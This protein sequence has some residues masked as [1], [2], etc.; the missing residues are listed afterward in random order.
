MDLDKL[1]TSVEERAREFILYILSF[2]RR[3]SDS[4]Q[5]ALTEVENKV[6]IFSLA[7]AV[8]G[9]YITRRYIRGQILEGQALWDAVIGQLLFW[10]GLSALLHTSILLVRL[11]I[12]VMQSVTVVFKVL[13]VAFVAASYM[14]YLAFSFLDEGLSGLLKVDNEFSR[15]IA[16]A[17]GAIVELI[18]VAIYLPNMLYRLAPAFPGRVVIASCVVALTFGAILAR[19]YEL[20][21]HDYAEHQHQLAEYNIQKAKY[22]AYQRDLA[23]YQQ[24]LAVYCAKLRTAGMENSACH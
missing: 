17:A 21:R 2:F 1:L 8:I 18:M 16:S 13:P 10:I 19:D 12:K 15:V 5:D 7:A 11:P 3:D 4:Y 6:V 22:A 9:V 20:N 23:A 24:S 14:T